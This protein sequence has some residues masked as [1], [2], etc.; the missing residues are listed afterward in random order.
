MGTGCIGQLVSASFYHLNVLQIEVFLDCR[1]MIREAVYFV[2]P[3]C[4]LLSSHYRKRKRTQSESSDSD[5]ASDPP[6]DGDSDS[7]GGDMS[8][9]GATQRELSP[10]EKLKKKREKPITRYGCFS[11]SYT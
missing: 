7:E 1:F 6:F 9:V 8:H 5:E 2:P 10:T 11:L 3:L 4:T